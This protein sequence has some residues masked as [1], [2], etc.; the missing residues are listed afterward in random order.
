MKKLLLLKKSTLIL[1]AFFVLLTFSNSMYAQTFA[2]AQ[3]LGAL[4]N[5]EGSGVAVDA[6]GNV[7]SI[8]YFTGTADFD[9]GVGVVNLTSAGSN[10]VY[11]SKLDALGNFVW[12]LRL[13]GTGPQSG[14][15]IALDNSGNV[16]VVGNFNN[17]IDVDPSAAVVNIT[18][19]GS[20]DVFIAKYDPSGN[21]IWSKRF[22]S[23]AFETISDINVD[24]FGNIYTCGSFTGLT[25]FDPGAGVANLTAVTASDAFISKLDLNG[26]YVWA[27]QVGLNGSNSA[28][29]L[30]NDAAGNV[31]LTGQ[32]ESVTDFNPGA[33]TYTITSAGMQDIFLLKLDINGDFSWAGSMGGTSLDF[34]RSISIDAAGNVLLTGEFQG[35]ADLDPTVGVLN[36][37][38]PAG[39]KDVFVTKFNPTT[40]SFIWSVKVG[41]TNNDIGYGIA[42]DVNNNVYVTGTFIG[43]VDFDPG[44]G[45]VLISSAGGQTD[46]FILKLD[47]SGNYMWAGAFGSASTGDKAD[48]IFIHP[49]TDIYTT[50]YYQGTVD[51]DPGAGTSNITSGGQLDAF[52][53][54]IS[55]CTPPAAPTNSTLPANQTICAGSTTTLSAISGTNT[56]NWFATPTSTT[57]LGTGTSFATPTLAVGTYSYYAEANSCTKSVSRTLIIVSVQLCTG[58]YNGVLFVNDITI[59]P[60]PNNGQFT[61]SLAQDAEILIIDILGREVYNENL[62]SGKHNINLENQVPGLYFIKTTVDGHVKINKMVKN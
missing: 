13:G 60:N 35:T 1:S 42:T 39:V 25:D 2:W 19:L 56:I 58:I 24:A 59:Y 44:I 21:Y 31:Y 37:T 61:I 11:I 48:A 51:F 38:S 17:T 15:D 43:T 23:T 33:G 46:C 34:G 55:Q 27:K 36:M 53:Q 62:N 57:S 26:N 10:D 14:T 45:S 28:S 12:A 40:A 47:A 3:S 30:A 16:Y 41:D 7:Y 18:S 22:G 4:S 9:P 32:Y 54:K 20:Q 8:G 29:S 52:V 50:G 5:E 6:N 49:S